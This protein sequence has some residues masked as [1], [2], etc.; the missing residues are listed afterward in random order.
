MCTLWRPT[1]A[2]LA[3]SDLTVKVWRLTPGAE[4]NSLRGVTVRIRNSAGGNESLPNQVKRP[5][6]CTLLA[7][8]LKVAVLRKRSNIR[9]ETAAKFCSENSTACVWHRA[10]KVL[11][12]SNQATAQSDIWLQ[13]TQRER[14]A[15]TLTSV[16]CLPW[17]RQ[18][19]QT[20]FWGYCEAAPR[21][22]AFWPD[23]THLACLETSRTWVLQ[24]RS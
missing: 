17:R 12:M 1:C 8:W 23:F 2:G 15:K 4:Q 13:Q 14:R 24:V 10:W 9:K 18:Q 22:V 16:K 3:W 20:Q 6:T 5:H 21:C 11:R 19:E 7:M